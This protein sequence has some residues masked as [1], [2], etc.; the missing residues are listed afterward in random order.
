MKKA[1]L[2]AA[3]MLALAACGDEAAE[4][5][6]S[7]GGDDSAML[8]MPGQATAPSSA[9]ATVSAAPADDGGEIITNAIDPSAPVGGANAQTIP[10]TPPA[11]GPMVSSGFNKKP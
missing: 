11:S 8:P 2:I 6:P 9:G 10:A 3:A 7:L 5:K 4:T 1:I